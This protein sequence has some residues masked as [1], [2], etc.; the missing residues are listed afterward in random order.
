M[1]PSHRIAAVAAAAAL[2][3]VPGAAGAED[4]A[5]GEPAPATGN[6]SW[7]VGPANRSK[8][9]AARPHFAIEAP[10]GATVKDAVR[11][12]NLT[13]EPI[14]FQL[15]GADAYNT[16]RDAGFAL[17][18]V[19]EP[20]RDVGAWIALKAGTLKVPARTARE[21]PFTLKVPAD[22]TPGEHIGGI[23]ALN[24]TIESV[25]ESGG[26][27][28]GVRRAVGARVYLR[29]T[30]PLNP[31]LRPENLTVTRTE[32]L[33]PFLRQGRGTIRYSVVNTGNQR[34]TPTARVWATGAFGRRIKQ[35]PDR[36]LPEIL[37][38]QRT[39]IT[40]PW[41]GTPPL[42]AVTVRVELTADGGIRA[43]AQSQFNAV[44]WAALLTLLGTVFV[45]WSVLPRLVRRWRERAG[46]VSDDT[47]ALG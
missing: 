18:T 42:D 12:T 35:W 37:P 16:P 32:P 6:G 1:R 27:R 28:V 43:R 25:Q 30:G 39:E 22:A 33:M 15:Y 14:T 38:G 3:A 45:L 8:A 23:V 36:R 29:V 17:R 41:N 44:P 11:I 10:P 20:R 13:G 31:G 7:S 21:V 46:L 40:L 9:L 4:A 26:A 24:T 19:D 34:I 2:A 5:A 47:E